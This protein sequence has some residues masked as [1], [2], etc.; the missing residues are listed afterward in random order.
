MNSRISIKQ[1][2]SLMI[3][4]SYTL[5]SPGISSSLSVQAESESQVH[6][7]QFDSVTESSGWVLS[8]RQLF[9]TSDAGQTWTEIG[10]SV[11]ADATVEDVQFIDSN[12]G[13]L[14]AT[15]RDTDGSALFQLSQTSDGGMSWETRPLPFFEAGEVA[16]Y[17]EKA[18]MGWFDARPFTCRGQHRFQ[19]SVD[20]LGYRRTNQ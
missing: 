12:L 13:W 2:C 18:E 10:P 16:S 11:P 8:D 14:L 1:L 17:V 5:V 15:T 7:D 19:R 3:A 4:F 9:W 20:R 6:L